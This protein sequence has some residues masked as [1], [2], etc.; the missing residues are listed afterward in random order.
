MTSI[1]R[2]IAIGV[3]TV[4]ALALAGCAGPEPQPLVGLTVHQVRTGP[5]ER[6][7]IVY[8]LSAPVLGVEA[9]YSS[10]QEMGW[11]VITACGET[12]DTNPDS[13]VIGVIPADDYPA[14]ADRAEAGEFDDL[15]GECNAD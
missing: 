9:S 7:L 10:L 5:P 4:L 8:D 11:I 12:T 2:R 15:L 6:G 1:H 14:L 3:V 13:V